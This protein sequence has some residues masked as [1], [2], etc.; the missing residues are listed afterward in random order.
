VGRPTKYDRNQLILVQGWA[1]D[2]LSNEQIAQNLSIAPATLYQWQRRYPEFAEALARGKDVVDTEVE[3]ALLKRALGYDY[4]DQVATPSGHVVTVQRHMP[5]DVR[6]QTLWLTSRRRD[7]WAN[8]QEIE[9]STPPGRP[10]EVSLSR[11][12]DEELEQLEHIAERLA[13]A[14]VDQD[15][16]G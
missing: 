12:S 11:L 13:V 14:G 15:R 10:M 2:G 5:G 1:R 8:R 9:H 6:A 7:R 16:E 4:D 3:N